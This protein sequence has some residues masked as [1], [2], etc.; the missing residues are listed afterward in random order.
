M[1]T[2]KEI[3]G[4]R[5]PKGEEI[6][7]FLKGFSG[8]KDVMTALDDYTR[9]AEIAILSNGADSQPYADL[10]SLRVYTVSG[11]GAYR[12]TVDLRSSGVTAEK[13][14][15][16]EKELSGKKVIVVDASYNETNRDIFKTEFTSNGYRADGVLYCCPYPTPRTDVLYETGKS[17]SPP[18]ATGSGDSPE[19]A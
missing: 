6:V 2:L 14:H 17:I 16:L 9:G 3:F 13:R 5:T 19:Q 18:D 12:N 4:D 1:S 8:A 7:S 10:V 15:E 11:R